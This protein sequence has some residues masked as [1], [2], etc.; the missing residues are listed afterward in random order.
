[1]RSAAGRRW[2]NSRVYSMKPVTLPMGHLLRL[3]LRGRRRCDRRRVIRLLLTFYSEDTL[4]LV[5]EDLDE[6]RQHR[7]PVLPDPLGARTA[8]G[9]EVFPDPVFEKLDI[10]RIHHRLQ[11]DTRHV[12]AFDG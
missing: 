5:R 12:A 2:G 4:V 9:V 8:R 3:A 6:L 11:I 1:M 7:G 10:D